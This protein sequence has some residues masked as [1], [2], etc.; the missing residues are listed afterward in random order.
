V[1]SIIDGRLFAQ[2]ARLAALG[3]PAAF[4]L[5]GKATDLAD[6]RMRRQALQ[7]A[8][9]TLALVFRVPVLRAIDAYETA[10]LLCYAGH[11]LRWHPED[12]AWG[13]GRR[14]KSKRRT[15]LRIL[16]S[17]P[18]VGPDRAQALLD[19]FGSVQAALSAAAEELEET[20]GIGEKTA[21]RL[22]W[23]LGEEAT[24]FGR[25]RASSV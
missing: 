10:R 16:Q 11:Q 7:G 12:K 18:G 21:A 3:K 22:R 24:P 8:M 17:L 23:A 1:A 15:Q 4:I 20:P 2:A 25:P 9:V 5:E 19:R 6:T 14:P 13:H